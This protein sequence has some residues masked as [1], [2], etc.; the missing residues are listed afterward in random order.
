MLG[1]LDTARGTMG[2]QFRGQ[3]KLSAIFTGRGAPGLGAAPTPA[4]CAHRTALVCISSFRPL[5]AQ[6]WDLQGFAV[7][8]RGAELGRW[9]GAAGLAQDGW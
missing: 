2:L 3:E 5:R 4:R 8:R 1:T 9:Q 6:V 7:G